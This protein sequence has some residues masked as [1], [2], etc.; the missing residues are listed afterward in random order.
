MRFHVSASLDEL[1]E[2]PFEDLEEA[3]YD[4]LRQ[5]MLSAAEVK[6]HAV[7]LKAMDFEVLPP[8]G[9]HDKRGYCQGHD[10]VYEEEVRAPDA[11]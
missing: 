5:R 4:R 6:A 10:E 3:F 7:I 2:A 1:I 11:S 9:H 8:C